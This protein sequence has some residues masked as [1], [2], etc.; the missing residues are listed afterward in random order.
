MVGVEP[1]VT[2][3]GETWSEREVLGRGEGGRGD[4]GVR[5]AI[6]IFFNLKKKKRT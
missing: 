3:G 1:A 4:D 5:R 2:E 6:A